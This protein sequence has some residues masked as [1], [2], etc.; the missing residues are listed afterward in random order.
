MQIKLDLPDAPIDA[1][2]IDNILHVKHKSSQSTTD[3]V[4]DSLYMLAMLKL[5]QEN[6]QQ[7]ITQE[8][9]IVI[10]PDPLAE[11]TESVKLVLSDNDFVQND[12]IDLD[13]ESDLFDELFFPGRQ[14]ND[15]IVNFNSYLDEESP[16]K[17]S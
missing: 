13:S 3:Q 17:D 10:E 7:K 1:Y 16:S 14:N 12:E 11:E 6:L 8:G 5:A 9:F 4:Q 15:K 2:V